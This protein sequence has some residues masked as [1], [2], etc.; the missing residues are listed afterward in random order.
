MKKLIIPG[1]LPGLNEYISAERTNRFKAAKLKRDS[2]DTVLWACKGCLR[3]WKA[4]KRVWMHYKWYEPNSRRDM[5]NISSYGRKIIQDALVEGRYLRNDG[6]KDIAGFDD[7]FYV[8]NKLP[9]VEVWIE[10][11]D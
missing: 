5:D 6:W 4:Q 10:E 7:E 1:R 8:D 9:R 11:R 2:M 3:G